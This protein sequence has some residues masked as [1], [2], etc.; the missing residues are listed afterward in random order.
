[1]AK[2]IYYDSIYDYN[3]KCCVFISHQYADKSAAR[4]IADYLISCGIDVYFDEYDLNIN[5]NDPVSVVNAIKTGL[6]KSTHLMCL[7]S[8]NAFKSKW[9]P[10]EVGYGYEHNV[11]CVKLK[12][13]A[14][15]TMPEYL[16]IVPVY[17]G[18]KAL[19][20]AIREMRSR[21]NIYEGQIRCFSNADHPLASIMY[22]KI[23]M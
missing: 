17:D 12:D 11:F 3:G 13:V 8:E 23:N 19:D 2:N 5:R 9:V 20:I 6:R 21:N 7:L 4:M 10:W 14:F 1:M 22:D 16:Q 15:K 18:F